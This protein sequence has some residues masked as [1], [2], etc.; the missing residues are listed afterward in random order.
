MESI[1]WELIEEPDKLANDLQTAV[2]TAL[3]ET[4]PAAPLDNVPQFNADDFID[5][6][7]IK[8]L[9]QPLK[10]ANSKA[11]GLVNGRSGALSGPTPIPYANG[12][13]SKRKAP[14]QYH[15]ESPA[16]KSVK[17]KHSEDLPD[18]G[19]D[20]HT[21]K[22]ESVLEAGD[23]TSRVQRG[24]MA[25][26]SFDR[27]EMREHPVHGDERMAEIRTTTSDKYVQKLNSG[28]E[29]G[30]WVVE[31][32]R[33]IT[34]IERAYFAPGDP[35]PK[36]QKSEEADAESMADATEPIDASSS[37]LAKVDNHVAI[38]G[39]E[40]VPAEEQVTEAKQEKD[41]SPV[42]PK[43]DIAEPSTAKTDEMQD[44]EELQLEISRLVD[45]AQFDRASTLEPADSSMATAN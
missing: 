13:H 18:H 35:V 24:Q 37:A 41:E 36:V 34:M 7:S 1:N 45:A 43:V 38:N 17:T 27:I 42:E 15:T 31:T 25:P 22:A 9:V 12:T 44:A 30:S 19:H 28:T 5:E 8:A 16:A 40:S 6:A 3:G 4:P 39:S 2:Y 29:E 33:V 14:A 20:I 21:A 32:R 26:V 11:M 10:R 23:G